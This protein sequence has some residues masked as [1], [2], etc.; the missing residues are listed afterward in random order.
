MGL[1]SLGVLLGS[2]AVLWPPSVIVGSL[3]LPVL[4]GFLL[5]F[6]AVPCL[7]FV[8]PVSNVFV[9]FE[10]PNGW[11]NRLVLSDL[12][13]FS[14]ALAWGLQC[15]RRRRVDV[16]LPE[17]LLPFAALMGLG[18]ASIVW[19]P[20]PSQSLFRAWAMGAVVLGVS[21]VGTCLRQRMGFN[22]IAFA[23]FCSGLMVSATNVLS[24]RVEPIARSFQ[25]CEGRTLWL[26]FGTEDIRA[27][28]VSIHNGT[29]MCINAAFFTVLAC[30]FACRRR[31]LW[32][33]A[34]P[35]LL[36]FL[37]GMMVT[38]SR[39]AFVAMVAGL[40]IASLLVLARRRRFLTSSPIILG[41]LL[42]WFLLSHLGMNVSGWRR[43]AS[44]AGSFG[45]RSG[46][47]FR[48]GVWERAFRET[49]ESAWMGMGLGGWGERLPD[50][51]HGHSIFFTPVFE[52]GLPGALAA[53]GV[54]F[55]IVR[56]TWRRWRMCR[57]VGAEAEAS[58]LVAGLVAL[59]IQ[60]FTS[61]DYLHLPLWLYLATAWGIMEMRA[62]R[63]E[64]EIQGFPSS[65]SMKGVGLEE[66]ARTPPTLTGP[67]SG[68]FRG[69]PA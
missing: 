51:P 42:G 40:L 28:G 10:Q 56:G 14:F 65:G 20:S 34:S 15:I 13:I 18:A 57:K 22:L 55:S 27:A 50:L 58:V 39:G 25:L 43:L 11:E 48:M 36:V 3:T 4:L 8:A 30:L 67:M 60:G 21:S 54:L 24:L 19:A 59:G 16:R 7:I 31:A 61:F 38:R 52:L 44:P 63:L 37:H 35:V 49:S 23:W 68:A 66:G 2:G 1:A 12:V 47:R 64:R 62:G 5:P 53:S 32:V 17:F 29:A 45:E 6:L 33:L 41:A 26:L 46:W 9:A 69:Y